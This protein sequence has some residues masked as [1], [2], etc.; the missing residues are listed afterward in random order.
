MQQNYDFVGNYTRQG[1][2]LIRDGLKLLI[3]DRKN[4]TPT[5]TPQFLLNKSPKGGQYISSLYKVTDNQYLFDYGGQSYKLTFD[6]DGQ[7]VIESHSL[8][9]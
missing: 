9:S 6:P 2:Y 8:I 1:K 4:P 5:K 7:A 3:S